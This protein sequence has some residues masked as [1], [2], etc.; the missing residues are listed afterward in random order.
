MLVLIGVHALTALVAPTLVRALG[1]RAFALLALVPAAAFVWI[2][3][4]LPI[5]LAGGRVEES[6]TWIPAL[7][8]DIAV[9]L[10]ALSATLSLLVTGVGALVVLY[11]AR[12]FT[13]S[14]SG[15]R[16]VR[17][18]PR[19]LRR[20]DAR[21]GVGRRR[22]RA[23]RLLGAH[24]DLLVP[25]R[26]AGRAQ[27]GEPGRGDAGAAR[28]RR[29]RADDARRA[30]DPRGGGGHLPA[31][32]PRRRR[33]AAA[34]H[35]GH[36]RRRVRA[37]GGAVEVRADPVPLLAARRPWPRPL[38]SAPSCTPRRWSRPGSTWCCASRPGSPT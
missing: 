22:R 8:V 17:G 26:R 21:A 9:R 35:G 37:G 3:T 13:P 10:D 6:V 31:L 25:A 1:R 33:P 19:R 4:R 5:V 18:G 29:G 24:D 14:S 15:P 2:L 11:C 12:Y 27:A 30:R 7:G 20:C 23:L 28:H 34:R 32:R 38:R 16:T 36:G